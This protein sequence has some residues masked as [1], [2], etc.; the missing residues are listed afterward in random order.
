VGVKDNI[1]VYCLRVVEVIVISGFCMDV[2][3]FI[4]FRYGTLLW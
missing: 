3:S 2:E 1:G 4:V